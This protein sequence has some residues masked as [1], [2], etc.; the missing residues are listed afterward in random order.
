MDIST[1]RIVGLYEQLSELLMYVRGVLTPLRG[2]L[3]V[4]RGHRVLDAMVTSPL[5][6]RGYHIASM[7]HNQTHNKMIRIELVCL[8]SRPNNRSSFFL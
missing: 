4:F 8:R 1:F 6:G 5:V 3:S 2:V 7:L